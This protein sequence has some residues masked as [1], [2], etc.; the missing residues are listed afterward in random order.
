MYY[1]DAEKSIVKNRY[2]S[3]TSTCGRVH[4]SMISKYEAVLKAAGDPTRA[5]ILKLLENG[6]LC[7]CQIMDVMKLGQST[8][9][10]H[11]AILRGAGL[12][13]DRKDGRWAYYSLSDRK[14]NRY[15]PPMLALLL[16]WLDDDPLVRADRR[17]LASLTTDTSPKR[18]G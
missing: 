1:V 13:R 4:P 11:L 7:V 15:S 14:Q 3:I 16:G 9:S 2:V 18:Y 10:G 17:R 12:V 6:E 8:I 5:R